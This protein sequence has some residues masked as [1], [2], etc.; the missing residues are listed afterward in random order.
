MSKI[1]NNPKVN[2]MQ[3]IDRRDAI[4][5]MLGTSAM[6]SLSAFSMSPQ[7]ETEFENTNSSS[8]RPNILVIMSD[9]QGAGDIGF[10]GNKWA[11]TPV[12]DRLAKES[13][14]FTNFIAAPACTPSRASYLTGR[15]FLHTG[16]WGVGP[17]GYIRRDETFLPKYLGHGG[18]RSAHFG[19]WGE[20]WT[21]DQRTYKRGYDEA[22]ALG[23]GYQ[24]KDT[25]AD[26]NG[27]LVKREGWTTDLLAD[28]TIDYIRRQTQAR[29]PW[30]AI[31]AYIAPHSPWE[32]D[33]KY[34]DTLE[35]QGYSKALA[36]FYGMIE[37]MDTATGR[38][39]EELDRLG[40]KEN[41]VV[42]FLSD[43]GAT[44]HCERTGG[45]PEDGEDWKRR[46]Y[47]N[48]RGHKAMAWEN[49][50]RVPF[51]VRW[52]GKIPPGERHQLGSYED[53][54]PTILDLVNI[55]DTVVPDHLPL[56]GISLKS[57]L[58]NPDSPEEERYYFRIPVAN[59]GS[60]PVYPK[61]IVE[62]PTKIR[63]DQ[64]HTCLY[65]RRFK[66]HSL[67]RSEEALYD[68]DNDPSETTDVSAKYPQIKSK[69]AKR[70]RQEWDKLIESERGFW[71]PSV[72]IGDPRYAGM[73]RCWAHLP[74]NIVPC[75]TAQKV[76]GTVRCPFEGLRGFSKAGDSATFSLDVRTK[77]HY[78]VTMTG[79]KLDQCSPLA[80]K[81]G[82]IEL[83]PKEIKQKEIKFGFITIQKKEMPLVVNALDD[84]I[85][86]AYIKEIAL[87]PQKT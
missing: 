15:N 40:T 51:L 69:M 80:L 34:S 56:H 33:A 57:V 37:Q 9:D 71:M 39:L 29:Q 19:K 85:E 60:P 22:F 65:G 28:L 16:V 12:L 62:D 63:Y 87:I 27:T 61:L 11:K 5:M 6:F 73:K 43:N 59:E 30:Y 58:K 76:S 42:I 48:L 84:G 75:N 21:P 82:K 38:I 78:E 68:M 1:L 18:Y 24:H 50:I 72:L 8:Q 79:D 13:A 17:R 7:V 25:W 77:G 81:I 2:K 41:T 32:C 3:K 66:Y 26:K 64:M 47:L 10:V 52:P 20:G 46:N 31:T 53:I 4:R 14:Q 83:F 54:L 35:K 67:P 74:P 55:S 23:G 70:C 44:G 86:P 49:G 45:T 36:A